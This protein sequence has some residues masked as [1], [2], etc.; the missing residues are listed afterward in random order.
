MDSFTHSRE[1]HPEHEE[2]TNMTS[3]LLQMQYKLKTREIS[4]VSSGE[5][6]TQTL[7]PGDG[8]EPT[9]FRVAAKPRAVLN[10]D[11]AVDIFK[12]KPPAS[13]ARIGKL[14][15]EVAQK[16]RV[17][18]KT[19]RD[20]WRGR[21]WHQETKHLDPSRPPRNS[22]RPGRPMGR[23]DSAPR[24]GSG[25]RRSIAER[26]TEPV[27]HTTSDPFHY[28]WPNWSRAD[29]FACESLPPVILYAPMIKAAPTPAELGYFNT[30]MQDPVGT[31]NTHCDF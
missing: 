9:E 13:D 20:I 26:A 3:L 12:L 17:S 8:S 7:I 31:R 21:T 15:V 24:R 25:A 1:H 30:R 10:R 27:D 16:F 5:D 23:K 6:D 29:I 28:D 2:S 18:E 4:A 14:C 22:A 11:Q 19:V